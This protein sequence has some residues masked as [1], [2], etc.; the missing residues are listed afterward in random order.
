VQRIVKERASLVC[1]VDETHSEAKSVAVAYDSTAK[2]GRK[3]VNG[4]TEFDAL[5]DRRH[6]A[7][8]NVAAVVTEVR[9][10]RVA[11]PGT[12]HEERQS[13]SRPAFGHDGDDPAMAAPP[14]SA[15]PD[16][17]PL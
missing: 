7:R 15:K 12:L 17:A 2:G 1:Q 14:M 11:G 8:F 16:Q 5:A 4:R 13:R 9:D 6:H 3:S 10:P